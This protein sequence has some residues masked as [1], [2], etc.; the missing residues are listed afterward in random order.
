MAAKGSRK[1]P[2]TLSEYNGIGSEDGYKKARIM[3]F[4]G[5]G[6]KP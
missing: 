6:L 2:Y 3:S 5:T 1:N 4:I